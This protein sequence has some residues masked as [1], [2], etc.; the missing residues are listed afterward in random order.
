[1]IDHIHGIVFVV[2]DVAK[3]ALFYRDKLGFD[4]RQIDP[5][6]AYLRID[7]SPG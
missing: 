7:S 3:C 1:M 2:R 5:D 4:L 6:E